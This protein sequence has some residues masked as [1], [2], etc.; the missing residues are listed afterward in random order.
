[1]A[2]EGNVDIDNIKQQIKDG[3]LNKHAIMDLSGDLVLQNTEVYLSK[4]FGAGDVWN[5]YSVVFGRTQLMT[6]GLKF[7][8]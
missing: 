6:K 3:K 1:M 8:T 7:M 5:F 2:Q 4:V